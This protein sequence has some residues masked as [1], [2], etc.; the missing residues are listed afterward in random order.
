MRCTKSNTPS[1]RGEKV[2][3]GDKKEVFKDYLAELLWC[4]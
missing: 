2:C 4:S 1:L 3:F